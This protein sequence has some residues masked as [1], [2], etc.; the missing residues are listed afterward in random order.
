MIAHIRDPAAF[1]EDCRRVDIVLTPLRAP[2]SCAAKLVIDSRT[3][4]R[5]GAHAV[6]LEGP[7]KTPAETVRIV[8]AWP[9]IRR[10]WQGRPSAP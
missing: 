2:D 4:A 1:I 9:D 6:Y 5:G 8:T 3:T 10:P 7:D